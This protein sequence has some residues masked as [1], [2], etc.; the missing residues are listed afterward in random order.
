MITL[1]QISLG[2]LTIE[3]QNNPIGIDCKCPR[4][5]WILQS[6][7]QD[8]MQTAYRLTLY[9]GSMCVADTGIVYCEQSSEVMI[10]EWEALPMTAY[11]VQV[12]VWDNKGRSASAQCSFETGRLGIPFHSGWVEP[13]QESAPSL[14]R[15]SR[16]IPGTSAA[17]SYRRGIRDFRKF[18]PAQY[19]RIPFEVKPDMRQARI[20]ISAHDCCRLEINGKRPKDHNFI[21]ALPSYG[22][23]LQYQTYDITRFLKTGK[24]V[25]GVVLTDGWQKGQT[26]ASGNCFQYGNPA[27]LLL[28]VEIEYCDATMDYVTG[29]QGVSSTNPMKGWST[30]SYSDE[31][32]KPVKKVNYSK[33]HFTSCFFERRISCNT[34]NLKMESN[35]H[36]LEWEI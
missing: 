25:I 23:P 27:S 22:P 21:P 26:E 10:P 1:K 5:G 20:Y 2:S 30:P 34:E 17:G 28:D 35:Y 36:G 8:V 4:F 14:T 19:I 6:K 32:W 24:N 33:N 15:V 29:E 3:H 9:F 31:Y 18:R 7:E 12:T 13:E 16:N 11:K